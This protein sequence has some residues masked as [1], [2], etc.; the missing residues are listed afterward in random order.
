MGAKHS[1]KKQNAVPGGLTL[2]N[3]HEEFFLMKDLVDEHFEA[4]DLSRS[5]AD[6]RARNSH[7]LPGDVLALIAQYLD[8]RDLANVARTCKTWRRCSLQNSVWLSFARKMQINVDN[9]PENVTIRSL[10][11]RHWVEVH[12]RK[13]VFVPVPERFEAVWDSAIEVKVALLGDGG[14]GKSAL[15]Q[16]FV[17]NHF[18]EEYDPTIEDSYTKVISLK[19]SEEDSPKLCKI[20][21]FFVFVKT[22]IFF[23]RVVGPR[24]C[25]AA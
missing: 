2:S 7:G 21:S 8:L 1:K 13:L 17:S 5:T 11:L 18:P 24:L 9:R 3:R 23:I 20:V 19:P 10:V 6:N 16:K 25:W 22:N 15:T 4:V 12:R 14:C